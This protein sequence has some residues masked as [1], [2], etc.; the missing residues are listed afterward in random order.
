MHRWYGY[1]RVSR[2]DQKEDLERQQAMLEAYHSAK[3]WRSE[4]IKDLE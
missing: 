2:H 1:I 4:V 3:G